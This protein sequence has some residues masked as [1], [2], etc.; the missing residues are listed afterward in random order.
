MYIIVGLGNPTSKY[1]KTRHNVGFDTIDTLA[2]KFSININNAKH[3]ALCG[4]GLINGEKVLLVKPQT[5]M[6]LSGE[7]VVDTVN[8][9]KCDPSTELIVIYDD[10]SMEPGRLRLREKGSAGGHNG[11]KNIILHLGSENFRRIKI[12]VGAKPDGWDLADFVLSR[13]PP[14]E[15]KLIDD[16]VSRAC[17]AI[18]ATVN[19]DFVKAMNLYNS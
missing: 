6:N 7:A 13:F 11:I 18:V 1:D 3:K 4:S 17:D 2:D 16:A 9:Y 15:R 10:I 12:G 19:E 5:F 8:F 14:S